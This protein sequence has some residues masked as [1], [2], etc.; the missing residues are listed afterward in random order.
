MSQKVAC[1]Y[2]N[3]L[4][5]KKYSTTEPQYHRYLNSEPELALVGSDIKWNSALLCSIAYGMN[6]RSESRRRQAW[7]SYHLRLQQF[8]C[9]GRCK[10]NSSNRMTG[11]DR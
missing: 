10:D 1:H 2:Y 9:A 6:S 7:I 5:D 3:S 4:V 11:G 8:L